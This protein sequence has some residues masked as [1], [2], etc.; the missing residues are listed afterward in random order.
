MCYPD[1]VNIQPIIE[2][3]DY[4]FFKGQFDKK[5]ITRLR[6]DDYEVTIGDLSDYGYI[7]SGPIVVSV[8]K[9]IKGYDD[10]I[11]HNFNSY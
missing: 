2:T 11:M 4:V 6:K 10:Y 8:I 5:L 1:Y 7:T 9:K 3:D